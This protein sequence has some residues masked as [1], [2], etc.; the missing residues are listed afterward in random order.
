[1]KSAL[2]G[3]LQLSVLDGWWPEAYDGTN[4]W[5]IDG[6]VDGDHAAQD[7]RHADALYRTLETEVVPEFYERDAR[8]I[9]P[10]WLR[11]IRASLRS[12]G[13]RFC[14]ARMLDDYLHGP[15]R[16]S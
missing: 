16:S 8:G 12:I 9:P 3:G 11:R 13:P 14:A 5:A 10:R 4:G 7:D 2:N 1:M 15:Y 6:G